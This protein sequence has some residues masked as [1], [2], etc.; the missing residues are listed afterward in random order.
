ML[1]DCKAQ[2]RPGDRLL[3][4]ADISSPRQHR[5]HRHQSFALE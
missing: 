3:V 1:E 4:V 5:R 2:L